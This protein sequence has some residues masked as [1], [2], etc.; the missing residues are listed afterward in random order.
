VMTLTSFF[1][2]FLTGRASVSTRLFLKDV[3]S[4]K[5]INRIKNLIRSIAIVTFSIEILGAG[6]LY[7]TMPDHLYANTT[8][9]IFIAVFESISSFCNAGFSLH[10][11]SLMGLMDSTRGDL[12]VGGHMILIM[13][14]GLGFPVVIQLAARAARPHNP[15][16]RLSVSTRMVLLMNV[17]LWAGGML[18]FLVLEHGRTLYNV[19]WSDQLLHS[20]FFAVTTRTAG[21]NTLPVDSLGMATAFI[22]CFFMWVGASPQSTGGGIKTTTFAISIL[23]IY[24]QLTGRAHVEVFRRTVA[25]RSVSVAFAAIVLSLLVIFAGVF[26]LVLIEPFDFMDLAFEVVS[27]FGTVGL[28]RGITAELSSGGK[29]IICLLMFCGRVGLLTVLTAITPKPR[30]VD[31]RYPEAEILVG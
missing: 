26:A 7:L 13:L 30:P 11:G 5:G 25:P 28:S 17:I 6:F 15:Y 14:G 10:T 22:A 16:D 20:L 31:Y 23:H 27:A 8:E 29:L 9:R 3:L 18:V 1:A 19:G 2:Y 21:F 4:D 24:N 12:Y